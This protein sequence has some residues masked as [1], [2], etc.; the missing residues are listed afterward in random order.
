M[1]VGHEAGGNQVV[2]VYVLNMHQ[3]AIEARAKM[4][5]IQP[6]EP[7]KEYEAAEVGL[8]TFNGDKL[9]NPSGGLIGCGHLAGA[10]GTRM[11]C[12]LFKQIT[13]TADGYQEDGI[14]NSMML[15]IGGSVTFNYV[16]IV[17]AER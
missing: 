14:Q 2:A 7:G 11:F 15:N 6:A 9:I 17:G 8:I 12:N 5:V 1:A 4:G 16:F 13:R 10:S 3:V